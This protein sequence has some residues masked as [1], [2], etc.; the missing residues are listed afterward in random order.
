M[1]KFLSTAGR[2]LKGESGLPSLLPTKAEIDAA[3]GM[4]RRVGLFC[5]GLE[6]FCEVLYV[7]P[8][9]QEQQCSGQDQGILDKEEPQDQQLSGQDQGVSD[10]EEG[11][12]PK[13]YVLAPSEDLFQSL[14]ATNKTP[15]TSP[16]GASSSSTLVDPSSRKVS[17]S[18]SI[19]GAKESPTAVKDFAYSS[20]NG[21][22]V[23]DPLS[24]V[25]ENT[26]LEL[27]R[28]LKK[29][30]AGEKNASRKAEK[31]KARNDALKAELDAATEK[32]Q[33]QEVR[34]ELATVQA[35]AMVL[36]NFVLRHEMWES[37][38]ELSGEPV[39]A[40]VEEIKSA[41]E[42]IWNGQ[43]E[44]SP[45][46]HQGSAGELSASAYIPTQL[47]EYSSDELGKGLEDEETHGCTQQEN[48]L[49][50]S[51]CVEFQRSRN[52]AV[53]VVDQQESEEQQAEGIDSCNSTG[54][55]EAQLE[56]NAAS[57][58]TP[59][60]KVEVLF[61][62]IGSDEVG[63]SGTM[64][65][66]NPA[67]T[68][69]FNKVKAHGLNEAMDEIRI[70]TN[71][72]KQQGLDTDKVSAKHEGTD[73]LHSP[74][75]QTEDQMGSERL[76][77]SQVEVYLQPFLS[78]S[79]HQDPTDHRKQAMGNKHA[80]KVQ[81]SSEFS[82]EELVLVANDDN[83]PPARQQV[84][85]DISIRDQAQGTCMGCEGSRHGNHEFSVPAGPATLWGILQSSWCEDEAKKEADACE[86]PARFSDAAGPAT[87]WGILQ[88]NQ[89]ENEVATVDEELADVSAAP[90]QV[91]A[92]GIY[93]LTTRTVASIRPEF[94]TQLRKEVD[95][96]MEKWET[97]QTNED[98]ADVH[99]IGGARP[100]ES[101]AN[102]RVR[103]TPA[104]LPILHDTP[105]PDTWLLDALL[106]RRSLT[107]AVP[108]RK[109]DD[110]KTRDVASTTSRITPTAES[111][112]VSSGGHSSQPFA[113]S[114]RRASAPYSVSVPQVE[115]FDV[116][117]PTPQPA[118]LSKPQ[119]AELPKS[120][121]A[122]PPK[123]QPTEQ[124]NPQP[125]ELSKT[126]KRKLERKRAAAKKLEAQEAL[127]QQNGTGA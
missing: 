79:K 76:P 46:F 30:T 101:D 83:Q 34:A 40:K 55:S 38:H 56:D 119:P 108:I 90:D 44:G 95:A 10:K 71:R 28:Q 4:S 124:S 100:D 26:K 35:N 57:L 33:N 93:G 6:T 1:E 84:T 127:R 21:N 7:D 19:L 27:L 82:C 106:A 17:P 67:K 60:G 29:K 37:K 115:R 85:V 12:K 11:E 69:V 87:L 113:P 68:D 54:A 112:E 58:N 86:E 32:L 107:F 22:H 109:P 64:S 15:P 105:G 14:Y 75:D 116:S 18:D 72:D 77:M 96:V 20:H 2:Y 47:L 98:K 52:V 16:G 81:E 45:Q 25:E 97:A 78:H 91:G 74:E 99:E 3:K 88:S 50:N 92:K 65:S 110:Q 121:P 80:S 118:E 43:N 126:Q 5:K 31:R 122:D 94:A 9:P 41:D 23:R 111:D 49:Q 73:K 59:K 103:P 125:T 104:A 102:A 53:D 89:S 63:L 123:P 42:T 70:A 39:G 8:T 13:R 66:S 24:I 120:Q 61:K 62:E 48:A 51:E 117:P 114:D 36:S